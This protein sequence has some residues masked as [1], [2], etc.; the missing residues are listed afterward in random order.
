MFFTDGPIV[1][2]MKEGHVFLFDE[3]DGHIANDNIMK[4]K[5]MSKL[6]KFK[7]KFILS[8]IQGLLLAVCGFQAAEL[9]K[10]IILSW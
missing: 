8:L 3:V 6:Q 4:G 2:A 7:I 9:V 5:K 10:Y 1:K